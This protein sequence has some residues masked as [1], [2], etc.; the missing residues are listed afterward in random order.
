MTITLKERDI[1]GWPLPSQMSPFWIIWQNHLPRF[2][3]KDWNNEVNSTSRI[4]HPSLARNM[5]ASRFYVLQLLASSFQTFFTNQS[6]A[7]TVFPLQEKRTVISFR[8]YDVNLSGCL[9]FESVP[10]LHYSTVT[11]LDLLGDYCGFRIEI[12]FRNP[13]LSVLPFFPDQRGRA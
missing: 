2:S 12:S 10:Y 13:D 11:F 1:W 3:D 7:Q 9:I 4:H 6:P 5:F 8:S